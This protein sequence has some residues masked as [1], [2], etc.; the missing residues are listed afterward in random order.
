[1]EIRIG[2]QN[3]PREISFETRQGADEIEKAV[4]AALSG[5]TAFLKLVDEKGDAYIVPTST[6]AYVEIGSAETRRVGFVA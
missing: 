2:I 3:T 5:E 6:L 1:M 4:G